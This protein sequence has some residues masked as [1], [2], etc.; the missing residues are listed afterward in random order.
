MASVGVSQIKRIDEFIASR[1]AVCERYSEAFDGLPG[2]RVLRRDYADVSPFIY[3]LRVLGG[4]REALIEHLGARGV[5]V[6][7]HFVPVHRAHVLRGR[8]RARRCR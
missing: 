7:I 6:G 8:A 3:S 4:R 5:D 2:V 1:R